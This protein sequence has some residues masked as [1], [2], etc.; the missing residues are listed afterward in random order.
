MRPCTKTGSS[1]PRSMTPARGAASVSASTTHGFSLSTLPLYVRRTAHCSPV[2][3]SPYRSTTTPGSPSLSPYSHRYAL[4]SSRPGSG[5]GGGERSGD[6]S[7]HARCTRSATQRA[8]RPPPAVEQAHSD[9]AIRIPQ[10]EQLQISALHVH[11]IARRQV[12]RCTCDRIRVDPG[13]PLRQRMLDVSH[14]PAQKAACLLR[15]GTIARHPCEGSATCV[16][17]S[18]RFAL[19]PS[20]ARASASASS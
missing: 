14:P 6:R 3:T 16:R 8:I 1:P 17:R 12:S 7:A 18:L 4:T 10:S 5:D 15:F 11:P 20:A 13:M 19:P 9:R 2:S